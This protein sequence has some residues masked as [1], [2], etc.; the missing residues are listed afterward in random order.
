MIMRRFVLSHPSLVHPFLFFAPLANLYLIVLRKKDYGEPTMPHFIGI[1]VSTTASKALVI[2]ETGNVIASQSYPHNLS[3]PRPLWSEQD[4]ENWWE[5]TSRALRDVVAKV[6]ADNIAA[7]GLTG[8]MHGLTSLDEH[9]KPLRPAILWNDQRSGA[10]CEAITQKVGAEKLYQHI[11]SILLAGFTA[12]K[13]MWLRE[14]EPDVYAKIKHV[15]LP[16]DYIRYRLSG[17]Y[18][19][20]VA[21]GSGF[22][23]MDISKRQWSDEMI[24]AFD[25]PREWLPQL[26]ESPEVCAHVSEEA[27]AQTGLRVGTPIVGGAGDQPAQGVG[28]GIVEANQVS[29]TVGTSGVAF[30]STTEYLPEPQGRLHTFCHAIPGT[31][32][33]MGVMLSAAGGLRWLHD[34][35]TPGASYDELNRHAAE[36]PRGSNGLLFA[37]YL[38][39]ERNPHPDPYARGAF[40]GL[41]LRHG[42]PHMVRSVMEGVAFGMRDN[43]ELLRAQGV[44]PTAAVISGGAANSP[45]WRQLTT[46]IMGIPLYTVNT[47]EGAAFGAAILAAVGVNCFPD[48][49]TACRQLVRKVDEVQ[50]DP[51]G[52]AEYERLYPIFKNVYPSLKETFGALA[53]FELQ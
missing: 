3:T 51:Q 27:A 7:I 53:R 48:V 14:N 31:W 17:A 11:G 32:F 10:Q 16:K 38:T 45:I 49:P 50:P 24:A 20:D 13:I 30:A 8:Q 1:D 37:P 46:D 4:P 19:A 9:G 28:S 21:D 42:V 26:C 34:A 5:A 23:L 6:G 29:L 52:V 47:T 15:L 22:G 2:D 41:T 40:V 36:V 39:G 43:L 44:H 33:Y 18:V 12:P 35:V 25:I